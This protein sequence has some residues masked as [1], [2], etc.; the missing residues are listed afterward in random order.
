M[1]LPKI[2]LLKFEQKPQCYHPHLA[3]SLQSLI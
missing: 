2:F 3:R 1:T